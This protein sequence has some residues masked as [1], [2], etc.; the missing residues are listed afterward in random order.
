MR[1]NLGWLFFILAVVVIA[2]MYFKPKGLVI[3]TKPDNA[4]PA[5][6]DVK[7]ELRGADGR[8]VTITGKSDD[9]QFQRMCQLQQN[10]Q[11]FLYGYPYYFIRHWRP[12]PH[13]TPPTP[14][15]P[16]TPPTP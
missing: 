15:M 4:P 9:P 11:V 7:C 14:P 3:N 2:V 10:Q 8:L 1:D 12:R 6:D 16:P 13:P 5:D